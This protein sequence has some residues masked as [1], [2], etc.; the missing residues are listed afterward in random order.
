MNNDFKHNSNAM[1]CNG[2]SGAAAVTAHGRHQADLP[3]G[4][5]ARE[6]GWFGI[7]Q[8]IPPGNL[9]TGGL[10]KVKV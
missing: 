7:N 8:C 6:A 3:R 1:R 5:V 4:I 2:D 9:L 10:G